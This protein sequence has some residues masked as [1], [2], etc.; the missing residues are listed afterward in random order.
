MKEKPMNRILKRCLFGVILAS[1]VSNYRATFQYLEQ[2]NLTDT[3]INTIL[4]FS[5]KNMDN[6]LERKLF[7]M[8][9]TSLLTQQELPDSVREKSPRIIAKITDILVK[10]TVDEAK[11]ARKKEKRKLEYKEDEDF[12]SDLD[13]EDDSEEDDESEGEGDRQEVAGIGEELKDE[14]FGEDGESTDE[15]EGDDILEAEIDVQS[16]FSIMKTGFN[17]FDEFKYFKHVIGQLYK[18]HAVE[19]EQL[20]SQMSES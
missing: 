17:G 2:S 15:Q 5:V 8:S 9:L 3:V 14:T 6:Q 18:K 20:I 16:N 11:K 1:M 12:D 4:K 19:M 7:C 13:S 10:T